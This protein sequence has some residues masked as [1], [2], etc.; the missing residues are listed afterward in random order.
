MVR[1]ERCVPHD[2][3]R[4]SSFRG[5]AAGAWTLDGRQFNTHRMNGR[6]ARHRR[7]LAGD[8]WGLWKIKNR[9]KHFPWCINRDGV[10]G[11]RVRADFAPRAGEPRLAFWFDRERESGWARGE[12][13]RER[14]RVF[15]AGTREP[16]ENV[17]RLGRRL[18]RRSNRDVSWYETWFTIRSDLPISFA[19]RYYLSGVSAAGRLLRPRYFVLHRS[20]LVNEAGLYNL[21]VSCPSTETE[22]DAFT[23]L[24]SIIQRR[25]TC[26]PRLSRQASSF[27]RLGNSDTCRSAR[28]ENLPRQEFDG[29][30]KEIISN[31][32]YGLKYLNIFLGW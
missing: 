8:G 12:G 22:L 10:A 27:A 3:I 4:S 21:P 30:E 24:V 5:L 9:R 19:V 1:A 7:L 15:N 25:G 32:I 23:K 29:G 13:G 28:N 6:D 26:V 14:E 16:V 20:I 31:D 18:S 11:W 2:E 17:R